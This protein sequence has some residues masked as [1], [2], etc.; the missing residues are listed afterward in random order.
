ML[1][2]ALLF[3]LTYASGHA[4]QQATPPA[5]YAPYTYAHPSRI[6]LE[7]LRLE[8]EL[9]RARLERHEAILEQS[10]REKYRWLEEQRRRYEF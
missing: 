7:A 5:V 10:R 3:G 2:W 1:E 6:A 4:L 8:T 9:D